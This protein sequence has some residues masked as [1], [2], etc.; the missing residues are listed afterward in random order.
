MSNTDVIIAKGLSSST[1]ALYMT[2]ILPVRMHG[3]SITIARS[4]KNCHL[5]TATKYATTA[6]KDRDELDATE[7]L[8]SFHLSV[9]A[10]AV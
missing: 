8:E 10:V 6:V 2:I 4:T 1:H 9:K 5:N 7:T 3:N